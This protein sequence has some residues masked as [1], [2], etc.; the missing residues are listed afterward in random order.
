MTTQTKDYYKTL[1]VRKDATQDEIKKV[2]REAAKKYHPDKNTGNSYAEKKFKE[3][4]EAYAVIGDKK[5]RSEYDTFG[6][7]GFGSSNVRWSSSD[8]NGFGGFDFNDI[9]KSFNSERP[10]DERS[11]RSSNARYE[12][13]RHNPEIQEDIQVSVEVTFLEAARGCKKEV[14]F[15]ALR[16]NGRSLLSEPVRLNVAIPE[17]VENHSKIR[18]RGQGNDSSDG[19]MRSDL[20]ATILIR[21][22]PNFRREGLNILQNVTISYYQ[23]VM[24]DK[25]E[26]M[27]LDGTTTMIIPK[28]TNGGQKLRLKS[29][30]IRA[31]KTT[32]EGDMIVTVKIAV[33]KFLTDDELQ[34]IESN[35]SLFQKA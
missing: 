32:Y 35:K 1:G 24:G 18:V 34:I 9:F 7:M 17:G 28:G 6:S 15:K 4:S 10:F 11:G 20:I 2:Y 12:R 26:V 13:P 27:T 31:L 29:K 23:A 16:K 5:K 19:R 22:H 8:S 14:S 21:P 30:G 25:I 33:P 3:I